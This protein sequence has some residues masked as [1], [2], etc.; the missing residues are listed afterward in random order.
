[1]TKKS[2]NSRMCTC[3]NCEYRHRDCNYSSC[4]DSNITCKHWKLGK[5]YICKYY[6]ENMTE[7]DTDKWFQRGCEVWFPS[8]GCC[9]NFKRDWKKIFNKKIFSNMLNKREGHK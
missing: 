7:E 5:C 4:D 1:M 2:R 8:G 6:K 9:L 3:Y